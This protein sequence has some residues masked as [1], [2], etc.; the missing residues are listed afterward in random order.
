MRQNW[1]KFIFTL[2]VLAEITILAI[3]SPVLAEV[4]ADFVIPGQL[5]LVESGLAKDQEFLLAQARRLANNDSILQAIAD[6]DHAGLIDITIQEHKTTGVSDIIV[7]DSDG[8]VIS[9][10]IQPTT[11]GDYI[12]ERTA[13]GRK[14]AAGE[15][16]ASF[17]ETPAISL[18]LVA[19]VPVP[20]ENSFSPGG[21]FVGYRADDAYAINFQK[22]YL[23]VGARVAIYNQKG[24]IFGTNLDSQLDR[25]A[26]SL[27]LQDRMSRGELLSVGHD[28]QKNV[29]LNGVPYNFQNLPLLNSDGRFIGGFL[30]LMPLRTFPVSIMIS[31]FFTTI[32]L[33][34]S[35][36]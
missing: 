23:P 10:T 14:I 6:K 20:Q 12:Y 9:R 2:L 31:A 34:A 11:Y 13:W 16:I 35:P 5:S 36:I 24:S 8:R 27:Y 29:K 15:E 1:R 3:F 22:N 26:L 18:L 17:E 7:S 33:F 21:I 28:W 25:D 30:L 19:G 32:F 4:F